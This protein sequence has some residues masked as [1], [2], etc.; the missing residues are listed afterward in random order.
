MFAAIAILIFDLFTIGFA[1]FE[2]AVSALIDAG[3]S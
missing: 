2:F 3:S 1:M